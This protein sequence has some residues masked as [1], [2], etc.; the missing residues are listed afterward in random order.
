VPAPR[1]SGWQVDMPPSL[2]GAP[3]DPH[4]APA[5]ATPSN[6]AAANA[7][8]VFIAPTMPQKRGALRGFTGTSLRDHDAARTRRIAQQSRNPDC[9]KMS[10]RPFS[11]R[12]APSLPSH[13]SMNDPVAASGRAPS[14]GGSGTGN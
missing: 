7:I 3:P 2:F 12:R 6:S 1:A 4:P 10:K 8:L 11:C 9:T 5:D 13:S 14:T